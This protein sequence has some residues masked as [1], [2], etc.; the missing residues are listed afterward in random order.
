[1]RLTGNKCLWLLM[2]VFCTCGKKLPKKSSTRDHSER[3]HL[4]SF[5]DVTFFS[6]RDLTLFLCVSFHPC[7][8]TSLLLLHDITR[9]RP[10]PRASY[11]LIAV[12]S[13]RVS[14][15]SASSVPCCIHV[16]LSLTRSTKPRSAHKGT[17][18]VQARNMLIDTPHSLLQ[19]TTD[20]SH[21]LFSEG[22]LSLSIFSVAASTATATV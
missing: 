7:S 8:R 3:P 11:Y 19:Q 13:V 15:Q 9:V 17:C 1:M 5:C 4:F 6:F 2:N 16:V 18:F 12:L 22:S 14:H 20:D 10:P 21:G